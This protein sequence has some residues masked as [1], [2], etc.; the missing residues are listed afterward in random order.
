MFNPFNARCP[1]NSQAHFFNV[2]FEHIFVQSELNP[3]T[4]LELCQTSKM[5]LY[6]NMVNGCQL[7]TIFPKDFILDI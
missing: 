7:L 1:K 3:E 2:D 6:A 5:E 4:Y